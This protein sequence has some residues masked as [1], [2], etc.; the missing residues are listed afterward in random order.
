MVFF[1]LKIFTL[2]TAI[3]CSEESHF[4]KFSLKRHQKIQKKKEAKL[5]ADLVLQ[6]S[7]TARMERIHAS[8]LTSE[9]LYAWITNSDNNPHFLCYLYFFLR[10]ENMKRNRKNIVSLILSWNLAAL[11][12]AFVS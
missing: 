5:P 3:Y 2:Y 1:L 6:P 9:F 10:K 7:S 4:L 8:F 12:E 11:T